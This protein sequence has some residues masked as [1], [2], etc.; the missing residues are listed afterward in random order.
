MSECDTKNYKVSGFEMKTKHS[1]EFKK[2]FQNFVRIWNKVFAAC[3]I[4]NSK[5]Y[6]ASDFDL[7]VLQ[8]VGL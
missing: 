6:N 3:Q 8:R 5:I 1:S 7:I 2:N 4:W